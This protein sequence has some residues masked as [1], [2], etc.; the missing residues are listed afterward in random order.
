MSHGFPR[1]LSVKGTDCSVH[2]W[3][4][5]LHGGTHLRTLTAAYPCSSASQPDSL[6]FQLAPCQLQT[7]LWFNWMRGFLKGAMGGKGSWPGRAKAV[8]AHLR[9]TRH[10]RQVGRFLHFGKSNQPNWPNFR[11]KPMDAPLAL[12]L[13]IFF[14]PVSSKKKNKSWRN[15]MEFMLLR[16][17]NEG[18]SRSF[19]HF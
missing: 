13:W 17:R 11:P 18:D 2:S 12:F 19:P 9:D 8:N 14:L 7:T 15:K 10:Q 5:Q 1:D 16:G 3:W 6:S 4:W